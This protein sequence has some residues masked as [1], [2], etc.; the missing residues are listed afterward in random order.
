V[1]GERRIDGILESFSVPWIFP[2]LLLLMRGRDS[3]GHELARGIA[4]LDSGMMRPEAVYRALRQME[5]EGL[6]LSGGNRLY[7]MLPWHK[8]SITELGEAY[9]EFWAN[10]LAQC[11]EDIGPLLRAYAESSARGVR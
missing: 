8:Y 10:S 6:V 2:F 11:Q 3:C 9:L 7:R 5:G 4:D 1:T